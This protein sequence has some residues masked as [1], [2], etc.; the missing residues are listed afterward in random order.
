M[1]WMGV[2]LEGH[3]KTQV[4]TQLRTWG[5]SRVWIC[6]GREPAYNKLERQG[7]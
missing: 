6:D 4:Q 2:E 7:R 3:P 1:R 5:T